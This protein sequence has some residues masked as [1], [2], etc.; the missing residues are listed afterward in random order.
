MKGGT[1]WQGVGLMEQGSTGSQTLCWTEKPDMESVKCE[2][3]KG[4]LS[5]RTASAVLAALLAAASGGGSSFG[6]GL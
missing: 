4:S 5:P 1:E 6:I 2:P 3:E